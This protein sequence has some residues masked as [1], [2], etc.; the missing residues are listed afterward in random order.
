MIRRMPRAPDLARLACAAFACVLLLGCQRTPPA[1]PGG[2]RPTVAVLQL[3]ERLRTNDAAGFATVAVPPA[4][5]AR[6][7]TA[8]R[9]GRSRWPLDE[10]PLDDRVPGMLALLASDDARATLQR[11]FDTQFKNS[12]AELHSAATS[13]GV[14]GV[15]YIRKEGD[16]SA[17][18]RDHYTQAVAGLSRWAAQAPLADA[19]RAR[20]A[21]AVLTTAA[22]RTGIASQDDLAALGM[23]ESLQ[24]LGPFLG[25]AKQVFASYGLDLDKTLATLDARLVSQTGDVATVR[26]RYQ[27]G[28]QPVDTVLTVQRIDGRWYLE[29]H[30]RNAEAS[31]E[32]PDVPKPKS[33]PAGRIGTAS[34]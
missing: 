3:A 30:I 9:T 32:S 4:L 5:H 27:L 11:T 31:L 29:D 21:I 24:R 6:L 18:E 12:G 26:V 14:F 17:A 20:G 34:P 10:L 28:A 25:A 23:D 22:R 13:L 16:Y 19:R 7:E 15:E 2:Q 1:E 33:V 8:W